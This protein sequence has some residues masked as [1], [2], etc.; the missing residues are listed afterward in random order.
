MAQEKRKKKFF[1]VKIPIVNMQTQMYAYEISDLDGRFLKY[2]L[3]R[4]LRGKSI[5]LTLKIKAKGEE[6]TTTP[7]KMVLMPYFVRRMVR[8]G[9]NYIEDS[10][11]AEC[12]DAKL[13]IKPLLVTRKKVSRAVRNALRVKA[14]EELIDYAKT[15]SSEEIFNDILNNQLQ[16]PLSMKLKK[17]Y[18]LSL[19]EIRVLES[20]EK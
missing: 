1:D 19:C 7:T 16:K 10:F 12:K 3:T 6:V 17:I 20:K 13:K 18:P 11:A 2:D 8:K 4:I 5:I 15:K 9:T 14:R